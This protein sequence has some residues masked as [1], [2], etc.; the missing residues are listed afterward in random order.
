M[1]TSDFIEKL[2]V[3]AL[4]KRKC[5]IIFSNDGGRVIINGRIEGI[6]ERED[7]WFYKC[8]LGRK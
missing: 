5:E 8:N 1:V 3:L 4:E 6:Y 7:F 2:E